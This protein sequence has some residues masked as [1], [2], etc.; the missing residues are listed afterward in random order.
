MG[1]RLVLGAKPADLVRLMARRT[2][3]AMGI[4]LVAGAAIA[5][6]GARLVA[7]LLFGI[8]PGDPRVFVTAVVVLFIVGA[9]AAYVPARRTGRIDPSAA[10]RIE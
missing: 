7:S 3:V 8:E 2:I 9:L 4:G 10:L 5:F 6:S 1:I